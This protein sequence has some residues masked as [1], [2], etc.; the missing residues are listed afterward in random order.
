M[1]FIYFVITLFVILWGGDGMV[2]ALGCAKKGKGSNLILD[3]S[4]SWHQH[5]DLLWIHQTINIEPQKK[6]MMMTICHG[7]DELLIIS[8]KFKKKNLRWNY[9]SIMALVR[10]HFKHIHSSIQKIKIKIINWFIIKIIYHLIK[11][12]PCQLEFQL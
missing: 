3:M 7:F 9:G 12:I 10:L 2:K 8:L 11:K 1:V 5:D 4:W 6:N